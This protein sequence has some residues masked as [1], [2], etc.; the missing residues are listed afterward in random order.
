MTAQSICSSVTKRS[1]T[2]HSLIV[3]GQSELIG[4]V[5]FIGLALVIG[6]AMISYLSSV[7]SGYRSQLELANALQ[8]ESSSVMVNIV[9][10]DDSSSTLWLLLKRA[11]G[12]RAD[13]YI[14]VDTGSQYLQCSNIYFYNS[15]ADR[16]GVLC[17]ENDCPSSIQI[18]SGSLSRVYIPWEGAIS[19]YQT[20]ARVMGYTATGPI[21]I[22]RVDNICRYT[23]PSGLC[24]DGTIARVYLQQASLAR[25]LVIAM[26]SNTPYVVG[27][28]EVALR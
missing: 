27:V 23:S 5:A 20:Y 6:I 8:S 22:C 18:Y 3:R 12:S 7:V 15:S 24:Y 21:Y 13:Y 2:T 1:S 28:Y 10:Y 17:N 11:D 19:D 4:A 26:H 25:I 14:A 16:D 9:S